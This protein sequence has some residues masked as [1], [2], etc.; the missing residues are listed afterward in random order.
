[1]TESSIMPIQ[2][3]NL[4]RSPDRLAQFKKRNPHLQQVVRFPAIDG[5]LVDEEALMKEGIIASDCGYQAGSL[6]SALSHVR[7]WEKAIADNRY[8][9]VFEDDAIVSYS[10]AEKS[11]QLISTLPEDWDFILWGWLFPHK[12]VWVDLEFTKA[13]WEFYDPRI[14]AEHGSQF[15]SMEFSSYSLVKVVHSFGIHAYS[16]SPSGARALLKYCLPLKQ[17]LVEF[18]GAGVV[19]DA[20]CIDILMCGVYASMNAFLC[21]PPMALQEPGPSVR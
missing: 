6:G 12:F 13:K 4:D 21:T 9:T 11:V 15:Q 10:F 17:R 20:Y 1:M 5:R 14:S 19:T 2:L 8:V 16:V 7:L 3:I 18:P